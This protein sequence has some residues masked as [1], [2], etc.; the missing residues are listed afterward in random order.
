ML[1]ACNAARMP[2]WGLALWYSGQL[3]LNKFLEPSTPSMKKGHDGGKKQKKKRG[4]KKRLMEIMATTSLPA[5]DRPNTE[6]RPLERRPLVPINI[7]EKETV[8]RR[9]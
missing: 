7:K 9:I 4:K 2:Q 8:D 3:L 5:V 6:R 1:T